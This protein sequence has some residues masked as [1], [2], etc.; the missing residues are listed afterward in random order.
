MS[1]EKEDLLVQAVDFRMDELQVINKWRQQERSGTEKTKLQELAWL[2]ITDGPPTCTSSVAINVR[3]R[4]SFPPPF[5]S[6]QPTT[7]ERKSG[8]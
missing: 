5:P 8:G 1:E 6:Y 2:E 3:Y 4:P 7:Q